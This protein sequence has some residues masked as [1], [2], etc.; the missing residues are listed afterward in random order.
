ML[1][2]GGDAAHGARCW[3]AARWSSRTA[4]RLPIPKREPLSLATSDFLL[5]VAGSEREV[6][7][8]DNERLTLMDTLVSVL[9][10]SSAES[11]PASSPDRRTISTNQLSNMATPS[12]IRYEPR[13]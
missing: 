10:S 8:R 12:Y 1:V 6:N 13:Q 3:L 5:P 4:A 11:S 9:E 7:F 2:L